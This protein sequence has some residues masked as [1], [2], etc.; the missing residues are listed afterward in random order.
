MCH[1][2]QSIWRGGESRRGLSP[3]DQAIDPAREPPLGA[4][5]V[6]PR[7]GYTHHGI[8]VGRGRV[9]QYGGLCRGLRRGPVEEVV[10]SQFAQ[11]RAIYVRL[12]DSR[13]FAREEVV[14]RA[15]SRIGENCYNVIT[16]NCEHFCEWCVHGEHQSYQVDNLLGQCLKVWRGIAGFWNKC[17]DGSSEALVNTVMAVSKSPVSVKLVC[18]MPLVMGLLLGGCISS[19]YAP[20]KEQALESSADLGFSATPAPVADPEWWTVYQDAQL[21]HLLRGA[22]ADNPTL[23]QS[24]ARVREAQAEAAA[25]HA[26]SWPSTAYSATETRKR[27]SGHDPIPPAYA[28]TPRW[29]GTQG[30]NLSWDLDFWGR[31]AALVAQANTRSDAA[32]LDSAGARLAI[33]GAVV[34]SYLELDRA[35]AL[36]DVAQRAEQQRLQILSITQRRF[37]VGLDTK[38]ELRQAEGA[39]A[40]ARVDLTQVHAERDRAVHLLAALTG[41]GATAHDTIQRPRLRAETALALPGSLPFDLL[42]RR[43]DVLAAHSRIVSARAGLVA[44]KAAFYP[45]IN[46]LAFAGTSAIGLDNLFHSS[47]RTYGVGSAI[48]LPVF[49]AGKLRA[50]YRGS[51]AEV[52]LAVSTYNQTVLEAVQQTADQISNIAAL[53]SGLQQQQQ[54]LDAAEDA[55]RLATERYQAGLTTYLSVL[56]TETEVLSARRQRVELLSARDIAR[57]TLLIDVG[58]DFH[59]DSTLASATTSH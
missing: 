44:A 17:P 28:G 33:V 27:F 32:A 12:A 6:S 29:Q 42:A 18:A 15:R 35:Y 25:V 22:L 58:G 20:P 45:D 9:V 37:K 49:D 11:G 36:A 3:S 26:D 1:E 13:R 14:R 54:S 5:M 51:A 4:H 50:L 24:L 53:D 46:L 48:H 47:S 52:D 8:Y 59:L 30:F 38:V 41:Q 55:F 19:H 39:V 57:V 2:T 40:D 10:V 23:A 31:Q 21:D 7:R 43:P 34:R 56:T 16:N